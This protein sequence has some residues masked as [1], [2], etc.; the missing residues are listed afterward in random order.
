M[1]KFKKLNISNKEK[2]DE[3]LVKGIVEIYKEILR[4]DIVRFPSGTWMRPDAT[5]N[6]IKCIK[7]LI[8]EKLKLTDNDIKE[9]V[10]DKF[11]IENKFFERNLQKN[12]QKC[13]NDENNAGICE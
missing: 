13:R 3:I 11:F 5:E 9:M 8:E 2:V 1:M 4:G 7:Y 6:A 10:S 12:L